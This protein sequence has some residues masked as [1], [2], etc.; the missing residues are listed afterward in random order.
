MLACWQVQ[1]LHSQT[2][3]Q[4]SPPSPAPQPGGGAFPRSS[5]RLVFEPRL[6]L[7]RPVLDVTVFFLFLL[8]SLVKMQP[9]HPTTREPLLIRWDTPIKVMSF[10][11]I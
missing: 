2:L 7:P 11:L 3:Q 9:P 10:P 4:D 5:L 1:L 6:S 8:K